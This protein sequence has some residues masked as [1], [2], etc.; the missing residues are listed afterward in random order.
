[1]WNPNVH[2][3][4]LKNFEVLGIID[5]YESIIA[6]VGYECIENHV[7]KTCMGER[8][9]PMLDDLSEKVVPSIPHFMQEAS[10]PDALCPIFQVTFHLYSFFLSYT[11]SGDKAYWRK[12][13]ERCYRELGLV[14]TST[15]TR[16][17]AI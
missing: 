13:R 5:R 7:L 9:N 4:L 6:S 17:S 8:E 11:P 16:P 3:I 14:L 10:Q 15:S 12:R 2:T 1:M